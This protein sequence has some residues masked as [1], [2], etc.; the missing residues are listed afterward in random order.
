MR[1]GIIGA[2]DIA[3]KAVI[4]PAQVVNEVQLAGIAARDPAR[5]E[6]LARRAGIERVYP[7]YAALIADKTDAL[8][9]PV[10]IEGAQDQLLK[11]DIRHP[12]GDR[13]SMSLKAYAAP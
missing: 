7:T 3:D 4:E 2:A 9:V 13:S 6:A 1:L 11:V 8:V 5:A 10:R 12:D